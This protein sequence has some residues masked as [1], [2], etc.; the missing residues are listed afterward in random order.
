MFAHRAD[1][2]LIEEVTVT[3]RK[4]GVEDAHAS[5]VLIRDIRG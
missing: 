3:H 2:V 5:M 1:A 4:V